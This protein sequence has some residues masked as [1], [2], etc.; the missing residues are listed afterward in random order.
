MKDQAA[1]DPD[2]TLVAF[3]RLYMWHAPIAR[4]MNREAVDRAARL[5]GVTLTAMWQSV[6][7]KEG[8]YEE[9]KKARG[10]V[11]LEMP[12]SPLYE[13]PPLLTSTWVIREALTAPTLNNWHQ[14]LRLTDPAPP[15][16]LQDIAAL[17]D[18][19][20]PGPLAGIAQRAA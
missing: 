18:A 1:N 20:R 10:R 4:A 16:T 15:R 9:L 13:E 17:V 8:G 7:W 19:P 11:W 14:V 3:R 12:A 6:T 2:E 5:N